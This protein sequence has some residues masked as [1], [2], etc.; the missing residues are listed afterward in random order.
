MPRTP[1]AHHR[2]CSLCAQLRDREEA[3]EHVQG[4]EDDTHLPEAA[5]TLE[6][7][8][9]I[10]PGHPGLRLMQCP[11]CGTYYLFRSVY[12]FLIGFGGSYDEYF[13]WRLSDEVGA[14]Y[15]EGHR[16]QPLEGM[17]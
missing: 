5:N 3:V 7:V 14:E 16:S 2:T 4:D 15:R 1:E 6:V 10:R 9:E 17:E 13:L 11:E 12:E 8:R